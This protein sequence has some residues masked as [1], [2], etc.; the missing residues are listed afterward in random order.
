[1]QVW[2]GNFLPEDL[3]SASEVFFTNTTSEVMPVSQIGDVKYAVGEVAKRLRRL[4]RERVRKA[5]MD[6]A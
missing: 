6:D 1:M 3:F 5:V 4:Y 2:E